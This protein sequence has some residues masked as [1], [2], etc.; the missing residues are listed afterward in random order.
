MLQHSAVWGAIDSLAIN[1]N[2]TRS[3]LARFCGLDATTFNVSKRF[4]PSGKPRWPAMLTLSK[5]LSA[6][7]TTMTEFGRLCDEYQNLHQNQDAGTN[8]K[9]LPLG[10]H[11]NAQS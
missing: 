9:L 6:T 4:E 5:I 1:N 10:G 8:A 2:F 11:S 3:G 7:G